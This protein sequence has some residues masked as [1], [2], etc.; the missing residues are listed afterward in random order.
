MD[1]STN[2]RPQTIATNPKPRGMEVYASGA[3][4]DYADAAKTHDI[5]VHLDSPDTQLNASNQGSKDVAGMTTTGIEPGSNSD[6]TLGGL[7]NHL[8]AILRAR[9]GPKKKRNKLPKVEQVS[10]ITIS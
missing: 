2:M 7:R 10:L 6:G 4:S 9:A 8:K 3:V 1:S 5:H